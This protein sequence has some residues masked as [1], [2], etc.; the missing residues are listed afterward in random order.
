MENGTMAFTRGLSNHLGLS[1]RSASRRKTPT[2][3]GF[4][5]ALEALEE[6]C[7]PSTYYVSPSG[8]DSN[9]GTLAQPF[10]TIQHSLNVAIHPGDTIQARAGTYNEKVSFPASGS[11]TGGAI[12]L[13]AYPSE[14]PI[15]DGT[16]VKGPNMVLMNNV[17]YVTISGFE[18]QNDTGLTN[19]NDGSGVRVLGSGTNITISNNTIHD[20]LGK[21]AMGITVYGTS[22]TPITNLVINGNLI[23]HCQPANSETLTLNGNVTNFKITNNTIHDVNNIGIDMIGGDKSINKYGLVTRNGVCSGNVVYNANSNYGGGYGAAIYVDGGQTIT[24]SDNI[25][26]QSDLGIEIGAENKVI[27]SGIVVENNQIYN[28]DKAG[29]V[30]GGYSSTVGRVKNC[31]F[32][33]NTVYGNDTLNAGYGQLWIQW[34]SNNTVTSNIF[35]AAAN[36]ILVSDYTAS[37][38]VNNTLDYNDYFGPGGA[39]QGQF[40]WHNHSYTGF[41]TFQQ[42]TNEDLHSVF[43]DPLFVNALAADF[44][45]TA[46]S[47]A[48]DAGS[49]TTGQYATTDFSGM[50]RGSPPDA[51]AYEYATSASIS[52]SAL[53]AAVALAGDPDFFSARRL[54]PFFTALLEGGTCE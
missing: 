48:I 40:T 39:S 14:L 41:S 54:G 17:S 24:V 1:K 21:S 15:L 12:T 5:P 31:S 18:I 2:R 53:G 28:N 52:R 29:L 10:K 45:L 3:P 47:A 4:R 43:A 23:Y 33:N 8:S 25:V 51:G 7:L 36:K 32:I 46:G 27:A 35:Y 50:T 13:E 16:G 6:R 11:A 22:Q 49:S 34:A 19:T 30:F 9:P 42:K 26:Y 38:N 37:G 44:H 20:I